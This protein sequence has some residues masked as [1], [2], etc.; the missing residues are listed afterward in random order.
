MRS[1]FA[2]QASKLAA[3][4]AVAA[5]AL[6]A[7]SPTAE[8]S[9][10]ESGKTTVTF[11]LWDETAVPAYEESFK[12]FEKANSDV[13]VKIE[14]VSWDKYWTQLPLDISSGDMADVYW[15]NSSNYAK[16]VDNGNLMNISEVIG[17]D[18]DAW[19]QSAVD[20]YTREGSI[21]GVPQLWDSIALY[22]NKDL[23]EAA[24]VDVNQLTWAPNAGEG[25]TLLAATQKLTKDSAGNDASSSGFNASATQVFGFN[26]QADLQAIYLPFIGEAGGSYQDAK[27]NLTI[28]SDAGVS[29][30]QYLID[31]IN[32][33]KVAPPASETNTNGDA[34]RDMFLQ[35]KLALYQSGPYNLKNIAESGTK[36]NWGLAPM[37]AG[38]QGRVS[39]V[40]SVVAVGNAQTKHKDATVKLLKW[41]GSK[42]GQL[43]LAEQ[44]V[45]FPGVVDAQSAFVDYWKAKG[46]D[47]SVFID[48]ANGTTTKPPVGVAANAQAGALSPILLDTFLGTYPVKEGITKAQDAG[49]AETAKK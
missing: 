35:G 17:Q 22:Y 12:A 29:A 31:L 41:L 9:S 30:F 38:P 46:V 18:H 37:V 42:D 6:A 27:D 43:P 45:S 14:L 49:N 23:V 3:G 8:N 2:K 5:M 7:C 39:T 15:V 28:A 36:V 32:K 11:R 44:G 33:Y 20:L 4:A 1:T 19:Q 10:E 21:W 48:A 24:G 40:H 25:D 13:K 34:T 47:V 26:A 16:Y